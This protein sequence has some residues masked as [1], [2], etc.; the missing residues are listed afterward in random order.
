MNKS[1]H[2]RKQKSLNV[3]RY[4]SLGISEQ[5]SMGSAP[6]FFG[7]AVLDVASEVRQRVSAM[8]LNHGSRH[9]RLRYSLEER[10]QLTA[11]AFRT[12]KANGP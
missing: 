12:E 5:R 8:S 10:S 3:A 2:L 1:F 4:I 6:A 9:E 7:G 11:S